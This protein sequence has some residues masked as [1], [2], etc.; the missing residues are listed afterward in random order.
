M[1]RATLKT[2]AG[3]CVTMV[4]KYAPF[5]LTGK[6]ISK[7]YNYLPI[8]DGLCTSGQPTED[9]LVSIQQAG[10]DRVIN[11]APSDT[12]N[13]LADEYNSVIVLGMDYEHIPVDFKHPSYRDYSKFVRVL[14]SSKSK[15]WVHCA[16]NMRVS[17]FMYL[18]RCHQFGESPSEA[19]KDLDKIWEPFGAWPEFI[20][21]TEKRLKR[22]KAS[23]SK[24]SASKRKAKPKV[25][26]PKAD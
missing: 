26:K 24:P 21:K 17:V 2:I 14:N 16:A 19:K 3:Y 15:T 23:H 20:T 22:K 8:T 7:I 25:K 5:N 9:Q 6:R 11:L 12:E 10:F 13:A 1:N 18:Y 4:D